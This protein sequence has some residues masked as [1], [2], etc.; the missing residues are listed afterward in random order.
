[1]KFS[2]LSGNEHLIQ[3]IQRFGF[4]EFIKVYRACNYIN[5]EEMN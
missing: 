3:S 4:E 5:D 2:M 1:M